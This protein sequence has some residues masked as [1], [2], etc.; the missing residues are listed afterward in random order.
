LRNAFDA[1]EIRTFHEDGSVLLVLSGELDIASAPQVRAAVDAILGAP[2]RV[3]TVDLWGVS[4]LDVCGQ[5]T[6]LE[7]LEAAAALGS[8]CELRGVNDAVRRAIR[9]V[10]FDELQRA[11]GVG[12]SDPKGVS[13]EAGGDSVVDEAS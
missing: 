5:R 4:F 10:G 9:L 7:G 13:D 8:R 6:L 2:L 1:F 12:T 11:A 3:L